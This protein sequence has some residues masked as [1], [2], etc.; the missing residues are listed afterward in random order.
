MCCMS[1]GIHE[2]LQVGNITSAGWQETLCDPIWHVSSHSGE[3]SCKLLYF[4]PYR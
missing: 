1:V 3:A 4:V 2:V